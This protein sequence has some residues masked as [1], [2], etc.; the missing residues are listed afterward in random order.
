MA[1]GPVTKNMKFDAKPL[2]LRVALANTTTESDDSSDCGSIDQGI[3]KNLREIFSGKS[4][5]AIDYEIK[6]MTRCDTELSIA[7]EGTSVGQLISEHG[8][9]FMAGLKQC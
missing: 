1:K 2:D 6:S 3:N 7:D 5:K 4:T 9:V 8:Q